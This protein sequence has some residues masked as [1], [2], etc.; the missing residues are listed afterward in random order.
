M[1]C[2]YRTYISR[3]LVPW[4]MP[5]LEAGLSCAASSTAGHPCL[6]DPCR[7]CSSARE[8]RQARPER[9]LGV[10]RRVAPIAPRGGE[11][12]AVG[13]DD[14]LGV[15]DHGALLRLVPL[16]LR[17]RAAEVRGPRAP[18]R[19]GRPP[20]LPKVD[21]VAADAQHEADGVERGE[22][23]IQPRYNRDTGE[24]QG[25]CRGDEVLERAP[26]AAGR[27]TRRPR[28]TRACPR[29]G[30]APERRRGKAREGEGR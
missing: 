21:H 11:V 14:A 19:R 27:P 6:D 7:S 26:S 9:P 29:R 20:A 2:T 8:P 18:L 17:R 24:I 22:P 15:E 30:R 12:V 10:D 28:R 3:K 23:E 1:Q 5:P 25:R 13:V 16:A 4:P